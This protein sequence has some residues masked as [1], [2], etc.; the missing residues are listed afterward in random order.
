MLFSHLPAGFI[1]TYL[2]RK[3]WRRDLSKRQIKWLYVVGTLAGTLPDIDNLYYYLVDSSFSHRELITHTL[4]FYL[5]ICSAFYLVGY[6]LKRKIICSLSLIVFFASLS[7]LLLDSFSPGIGWFYPFSSLIFG[8]LSFPALATGWY[9]QHLLVITYSLELAIFLATFN[10]LLGVKYK[11]RWGRLISI[12]ISVAILLSFSIFLYTINPHLFSRN[13]N[14]YYGDYDR[15]GVANKNDN[16]VDGDGVDNLVDKDANGNGQENLAEVVSVAQAMEGI[17]FDR[18]N[19]K[20]WSWWSRFGFLANTDVVTRSYDTAGIYLRQEMGRDFAENPDDYY[21]TPSD[22]T[23]T[24]NALNIYT[25]YQHQSLLVSD[26]ETVQSG[27]VAFFSRH[28]ND[29]DHLAL[30][31]EVQG[32]EIILMEAGFNEREVTRVNNN[33][34]STQ[35]GKT[36]AYGRILP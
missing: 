18:T 36:I 34:M 33:R 2:T 17:Y 20:Y 27:D 11:K 23:F 9:G 19:K 16:D 6:L 22:N 3:I 12:V 15:D 10:I 25:Y 14:I 4:F 29:V 26:Q 21:R 13:A 5:I 31:I 1:V 8:L 35:L 24:N 32:S 28:S 30:V 7:H